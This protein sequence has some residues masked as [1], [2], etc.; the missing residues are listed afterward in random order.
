MIFFLEYV[1][2]LF[3]ICS[4]KNLRQALHMLT[5]FNR[6][7]IASISIHTFNPSQSLISAKSIAPITPLYFVFF[8]FDISLSLCFFTYSPL[9]TKRKK[10]QKNK[11]T[12]KKTAK[13][14]QVSTWVF[15][16]FF[17]VWHFS[18]VDKNE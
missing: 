18:K 2:D 16:W 13:N 7:R 9:C 4:R 5:A 12:K 14:T 6:N 17:F 1:W 10:K 15:H 3:H 8:L 11:K